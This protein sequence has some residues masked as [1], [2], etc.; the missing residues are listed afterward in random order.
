RPKLS[1]DRMIIN[2]NYAFTP[3]RSRTAL[4]LL[5]VVAAAV[6]T[7]GA[8]AA[9]SD[10][11]PAVTF[12]RLPKP[13]LLGPQKIAP[14]VIE[15]TTNGQQAE[16]FVVV[17]GKADLSLAATLQTKAE[18]GRYVYNTLLNKSRRTQGPILQWLQERKL[19]HRSFYIVN[20]ILMK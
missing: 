5:F 3:L 1:S 4:S 8:V 6:A 15:H 18:K 17:I 14:W 9:K 13:S 10:G 12:R 2:P 11:F 16:F 20:A 7:M 19:E